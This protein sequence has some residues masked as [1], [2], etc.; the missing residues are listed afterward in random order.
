L[1]SGKKLLLTK[2]KCNCA[3]V[4]LLSVQ[5]SI[6]SAKQKILNQKKIKNLFAW[7]VG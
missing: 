1:V 7:L 5:V 4:L 6:A 2:S 3:G